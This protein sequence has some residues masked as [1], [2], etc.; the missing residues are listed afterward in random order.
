MSAWYVLAALGLYHA[1]PGSQAWELSSP[2]F[3]HALLHLGGRRRLVVDADGASRLNRYVQSATLDGR[4]LDRTWLPSSRVHRG[5]RLHYVLAAMPN[6]SWATSP[7]A[8]PP[9]LSR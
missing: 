2:A 3:P 1:A 6:R 9:A 7:G 8:A 4:P 5:G